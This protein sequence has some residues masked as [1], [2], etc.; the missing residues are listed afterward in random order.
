[1]TNFLD[2]F[3]KIFVKNEMDESKKSQQGT[4]HTESVSGRPIALTDEALVNL[5]EC[6]ESTSEDSCSC[7]EAFA[8]LD[9]FVDL[10]ASN[11]EAARLMPLVKNHLDRCSGC[12][13]HYDVLLQIIKTD[14]NKADSTAG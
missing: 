10:V 5:M 4:E 9:E 13:E 2:K 11:D 6:L 12:S 14:M 7:E 1:M 8:M 3:K